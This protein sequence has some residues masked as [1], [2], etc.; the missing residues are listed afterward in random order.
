MLNRMSVST[1]EVWNLFYSSV[2]EG[3]LSAVEHNG[4]GEK[5]AGKT[6]SHSRLFY[7]YLEKRPC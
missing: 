4:G 7:C 2:L 5:T 3:V 1:I 6:V